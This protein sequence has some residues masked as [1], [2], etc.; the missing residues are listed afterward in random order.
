MR[1]FKRKFTVGSRQMAAKATARTARA[2]AKARQK[3]WK[4][5]LCSTYPKSSLC[6][7]YLAVLK[8]SSELGVQG[9]E[10]TA[11]GENYSDT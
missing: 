1:G 9:S 3:Q 5:P 8:D 7:A 6:S 4:F 2:T 11:K 10:L